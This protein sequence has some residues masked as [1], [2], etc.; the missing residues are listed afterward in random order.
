MGPFDAS[1]CS[2]TDLESLIDCT[3]CLYTID[4]DGL[5]GLG[6]PLPIS[7]SLAIMAL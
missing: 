2:V 3:P 1:L 4:L 5:G 7:S 6:G